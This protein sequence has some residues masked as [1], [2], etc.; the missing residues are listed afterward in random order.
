MK[1]FLLL[2]VLLAFLLSGAV[3]AQRKITGKVTSEQDKLAVIGATV[4]V[5][6]TTIGTLSDLDGKYEIMVPEK[7]KT[8]VFSFV[9]LKT[10]E[11]TIGTS[12]EINVIMQSD[13]LK[14][15][16]LV[17]TALGVPREKKS[18]GYA[19]QEVSGEEITTVQTDNF[20][21]NLS[22]KISGLQITRNTKYGGVN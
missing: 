3:N 13:I 12:D 2:F 18:L 15:D 20:I 22:G 8:L 7:Y 16:E 11:V 14:L 4:A 9:G 17:V 19:T 1:K 5:K 6:G 21:N 10:Q